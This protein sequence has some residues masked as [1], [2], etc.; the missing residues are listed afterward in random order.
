MC[1]IDISSI[2]PYYYKWSKPFSRGRT[3]RNTR[4]AL[5]G[6]AALTVTLR[7]ESPSRMSTFLSNKKMKQIEQTFGTA[8]NF[9]VVGFVFI[10]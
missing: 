1:S 10:P 8:H 2:Y 5:L 6:E 7:H 9:D 3:P 4:Y